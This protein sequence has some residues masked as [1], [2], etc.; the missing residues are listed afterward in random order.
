MDIDIKKIVADLLHEN[1]ASDV[2]SSGKH[3][4]HFFFLF[5]SLQARNINISFQL[6]IFI[7]FRRCRLRQHDMYPNIVRPEQTMISYSYTYRLQQ[8]AM[9]FQWLWKAAETTLPLH[10]DS[11]RLHYVVSGSRIIMTNNNKCIHRLI[12]TKLS[13]TI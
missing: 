2:T 7:S 3:T 4:H 11:N 1:L 6:T 13:L 5:L 10:I 12:G 9:T 8:I